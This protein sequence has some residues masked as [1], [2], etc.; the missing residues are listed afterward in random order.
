MT[1]PASSQGN[2]SAD[3]IGD[4]SVIGSLDPSLVTTV[5]VDG[6]EIALDSLQGVGTVGRGGGQDFSNGQSGPT[7]RTG[8]MNVTGPLSPELIQRIVRKSGPRIRLCYE[9]GLRKN[10][11]L[12]GTVTVLFGVDT[13]GAA[14]AVRDGGSTLGD[15]DVVSCVLRAF[16]NLSFP[17]PKEKDEVRVSYPILFA[18]GRSTMGGSSSPPSSAAPKQ[19][20]ASK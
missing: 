9:N 14:K 7:I 16:T 13:S 6:G 3:A 10:P 19:Q 11:K 5:M 2:R 1:P 17:Q 8:A 4:A 15:A 12:E 18:S 20:P